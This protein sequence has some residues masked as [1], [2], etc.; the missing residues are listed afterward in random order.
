MLT[1]LSDW[2]GELPGSA[3]PTVAEV[4]LQKR[5]LVVVLVAVAVAVAVAV[6]VAVLVYAVAVGAIGVGAV[7]RVVAARTP[8][9]AGS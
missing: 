4:F 6:V 8:A 1:P 2:T 3:R 9:P 7:G 5:G